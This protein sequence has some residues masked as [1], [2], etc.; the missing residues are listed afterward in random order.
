[1]SLTS[2]NCRGCGEAATVGEIRC[3]ANNYNPLMLLLLETK[4]SRQRSEDLKWR[5]G[6]Q[7]VI[8]V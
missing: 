7:N 8:G 1:M 3:I 2:L 6:F 5:F 4:M